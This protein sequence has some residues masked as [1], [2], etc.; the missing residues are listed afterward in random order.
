MF[1]HAP[2]TNVS[3]YQLA[4]APFLHFLPPLPFLHLPFPLCVHD[5]YSS[6]HLCERRLAA[7]ARQVGL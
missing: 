1:A 6:F 2:L 5:G 3:M 7:A 4:P